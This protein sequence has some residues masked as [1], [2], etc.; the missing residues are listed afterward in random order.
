M[1]KIVIYNILRFV[2]LLVLQIAVLKNIGYYNIV[3]PFPYIL[4]ILLLPIGFPNILLYSLALLTGLSI[5]AFYDSLGVHAAACVAMA[6][7]RIFFQNITLEVDEKQS[8]DTPNWGN[9]GFKWFATYIV[10]STIIHHLVLFLLETFS[11]SNILQT[12]SSALL[13]SLFTI[14]LIFLFSLLTYRGKKR[15]VN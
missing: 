10:L 1:A 5:D 6:F 13:S 3:A 2:V 4:I 7:F 9:Q 8:M 11:F 14:V 12:L 15:F